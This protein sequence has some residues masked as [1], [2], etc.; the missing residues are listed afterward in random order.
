M[1]RS[2]R[3]DGAAERPEGMK[4][5]RK[6][7]RQGSPDE[8][9]QTTP[10]A[11]P[12]EHSSLTTEAAGDS[13]VPGPDKANSLE[14]A[15]ELDTS[16][17][18]TAGGQS[19]A[20]NSPG[21][22]I[23]SRPWLRSYPE[24]IPHEIGPFEHAS[25]GDFMADTCRRYA[26]RT[27]FISLGRELS[28][29][30]LEEMSRHLAAWFLSL[31]LKKG[32]RVALMMPNVLQYPI[33]LMAVLRAGLVVV[34]VNPLYTAPEL[35]RQLKDAGAEAIIV[36]ENFAATLQRTLPETSV[37]HVVV[38]SMGDLL[39][40]KGFAVNFLL[41]H[42]KRMIPA[43]SIPGHMPFRQ[44]LRRGARLPFDPPPVSLDDLAFLQYTGGTTGVAKGAMLLHRNI[45][46][47][48]MQNTEWVQT[49][50][51]RRPKP[52]NLFM[53]CALPLYHVYALTVNALMG[54]RLGATNLLIANPRD[55]PGFIRELA[56]YPFNIIVGLNTL[57]NAMLN[58]PDF[59]NLNFG[60][61]I[62]TLGGG[63]AV[64]PTVAE[65]WKRVT[66]GTIHEG[67]GLSETSPV[68]AANRFCDDE[69]TGTI[70]LPIPST[71]VKICGEGGE[72][73]GFNAVGELCVKGPQV[74]AGYWQHPEET[75]AAF[76]PD[77]YF[78]TG[79]MAEMDEQGFI[80]IVDRKKDMIIVSGF[81]VYPNEIEA[82]VASHPGVLEAAVIGVPHRHSGEV[83]KVFVVR[84]DP[85]LTERDILNYCRER[86]TG[87]KRPRYVE[88]RDSLP[89]SPVGK[90]L[91]RELKE[92]PLPTGDEP[93]D[94]GE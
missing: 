17:G 58:N 1:V 80:R 54:M 73:R 18:D 90:L 43:W 89:K 44:A 5:N 30:K 64:Q 22:P 20:S 2:T 72:P 9:D 26:D 88:F 8:I 48:M 39:G 7:E 93:D 79:D 10:A 19:G 50:F 31:G 38:A 25:I 71:D 60:N 33:A 59:R 46:A 83:P 27:A 94:E 66:G 42:V 49:A 75:A 84:K 52:D 67:Y 63:M 13:P 62:L 56:R 92:Q 35:A 87:Y 85:N 4:R 40:L 11:P 24:G 3:K 16:A 41:R 91:R 14:E 36:L 57:F 23:G 65:R 21:N 37:R 29:G 70:G 12:E 6:T 81:N 32:S 55:I 28:F 77:G 86:L 76:T 51:I 74:M 53:V 69:F 34:N 78:R 61:L 47:N 82:V 15:E 68:V 45:L